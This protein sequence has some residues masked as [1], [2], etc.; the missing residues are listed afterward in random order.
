MTGFEQASL[1]DLS[2]LRVD[3]VRR[4]LTA[5]FHEN[6]LW[7]DCCGNTTVVE[8]IPRLPAPVL[9]AG[10]AGSLRAPMPG[11]ILELL[12]EVGQTVSKGQ[13]LLKLEAMKMEH[14]I[15][16]AAEG[17]VTAVYYQPGD[18]VVADAELVRIE[19]ILS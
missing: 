3:G 10:A 8:Y 13:P 5:V 18:T 12:V 2:G 6:N 11:S 4:Q 16:T 15:R 9:A 17:V 1:A 14:T 7:V 19:A